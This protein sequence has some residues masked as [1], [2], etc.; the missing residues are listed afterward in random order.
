[1]GEPKWAYP[2]R[3]LADAW[4]MIATYAVVILEVGVTVV[5]PI[6]V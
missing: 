1:M 6:W 5:L 2:R 4:L 3:T